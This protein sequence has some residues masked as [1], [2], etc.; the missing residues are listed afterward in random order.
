MP[1][2]LP[3][4][5]WALPGRLLPLPH[6]CCHSDGSDGQR[7][8][9]GKQAS[10]QNPRSVLYHSWRNWKSKKEK[11]TTRESRC[12]DFCSESEIL[13]TPEKE[14]ERD[15][16]RGTESKQRQRET[17]THTHTHAHTE[18]ER[19]IPYLKKEI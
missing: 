14:R 4:P 19:K 17:H 11:D 3:I 16:D 1:D 2:A 6:G 12:E 8:D 7:P 13:D 15:R 18:G 9:S 5:G 10:A